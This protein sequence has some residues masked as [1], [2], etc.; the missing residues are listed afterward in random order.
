MPVYTSLFVR[1]LFYCSVVLLILT[2]VLSF[3]D[4]APILLSLPLPCSPKSHCNSYL[5]GV[6]NHSVL[7][8]SV[9]KL[10]KEESAAV[11]TE[12]RYSYLP[13]EGK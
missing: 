6:Y 13:T 10:N 11:L 8:W 7:K 4:V 1:N 12:L 5:E 9:L 2:C 3:S